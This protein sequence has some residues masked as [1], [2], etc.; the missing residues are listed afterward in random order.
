MAWITDSLR[1]AFES[2][3]NR[4]G[5]GGASTALATV[6]EHELAMFAYMRSG[7]LRKVI[8]IPAADRTQKWRDW[9]TDKAT[10]ALIEAEEQ[11][12][13]LQA[14]TKEAEVLR[15]CGGGALLLIAEGNHHEPLDPTTIKK[16]GLVAVNVVSRWEITAKDFDRELSSPTRGQPTMFT[17]SSDSVAGDIHPTRVV[18]FRGDPIPRGPSVSDEESFWGDCRLLRTF[19]AVENSDNTQGWFAALV[20]KAKLLRVGIP[21]L[22]DFLETDEGKKKVNA[23][24]QLIAEGESVT[25]ATVYSA[26]GGPDQPGE[27]ITDYQV[28]WAG[29]PDVMDAF[30]QRVAATADI[31]F[32][33]LFGRSPAGMNATGKHDTDNWHDA[34]QDGQN[35]ETGPCL[36][37]IDPLLL[38]SAGVANPDKVW[39]TWAPLD[40]PTEKEKA[41]T[42][43]ILMEAIDRLIMSG[44]VPQRA[45]AQAVQNLL[46]ERG[47]LPGL[48]DALAELSDDERFGGTGRQDESDEDEDPS[49]LRGEQKGGDRISA[50]K[51]GARGSAS[52]A[53]NDSFDALFAKDATPMPLYVSR[54]LLPASAKALIAWAK[55][56]GFTSTLTAEQMHV[57]VLYSRT[58]VDPMEMGETWGND[59]DGG[60]TVKPGGPRA[61]ARFN[62]GAIVLQFASWSLS[63]RHADMVRAGGSHDFPEYQPHVTLTYEA[64]DD[65]DIATIKPFAGELRFGPEEFEPLDLNWKRKVVETGGGPHSDVPFLED[66]RRSKA[67]RLTRG[68]RASGFDP[69]QP[70]DRFGKWIP[71][72]RRQYIADAA[73]GVTGSG[74]MAIGKIGD[75]AG[76]LIASRGV[77]I[78]GDDIA[79]DASMVRHIAVRHAS[80]RGG[81]RSVNGTDIASAAGFLNSA[82]SARLG[83]PAKNGSQRFIVQANKG[84]ERIYAVFEV[85]KKAVTLVTMWK[86]GG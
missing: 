76:A 75:K 68:A 63:S 48:A 56:A 47:D 84:R 36:K 33:R 73:R 25:N 3:V 21:N 43:K 39:W 15:G 41:E 44:M 60:L 46:E 54:K 8:A 40:T 65:L 45:L 80:E 85:R 12:L 27:T 74:Q 35:T 32:T 70:R 55:A 4:L 77:R 82:R 7:M 37:K 57:T 5:F 10:I 1:G 58:A 64:P 22:M 53:A 20:R 38:R 30:D 28:T 29:I 51:G 50:G 14:K 59:E 26:P 17:V 78:K 67:Q 52:R 83:S 61:L 2:V 18:C 72:G 42:F 9:Q 16:G 86:R 49:A 66:A 13:E 24:V 31:P 62:E 34:V 6:F 79:I 69:A 19:R 23:R 71:T 11:R 81:Q